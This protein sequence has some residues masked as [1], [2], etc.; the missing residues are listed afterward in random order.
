M[1]SGAP[2]FSGLKPASATTSRTK[3]KNRREGTLHEV[4]LRRALWRMGLRFRKNVRS[5]P[6]KPDIVFTR[7]RLAVFCDGDF[8]HGRNW[9]SLKYKLH[10]GWNSPY[11][12]AKIEGNRMRD[13][14]NTA[15]LMKSGWRVIRLWESTIRKDPLA[16]ALRVRNAVESRRNGTASR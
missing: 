4:I 16:A 1:H 6:G 9:Q 8:W 12:V 13:R 7:A 3:K 14:R 15:L 10:R 5:L 2:S 11:W